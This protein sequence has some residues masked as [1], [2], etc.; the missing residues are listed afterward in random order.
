MICKGCENRRIRC[1]AYGECVHYMNEKTLTEQRRTDRFAQ[2]AGYYGIAE[3]WRVNAKYRGKVR[4]DS[5]K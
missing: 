5:K 2:S 4:R 1:H 3:T